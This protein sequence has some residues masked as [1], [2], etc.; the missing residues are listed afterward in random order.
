MMSDAFA[1][2]LKGSILK[3]LIL[4]AH[5]REHVYIHGRDS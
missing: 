3:V 2:Y 5:M 4:R 1:T